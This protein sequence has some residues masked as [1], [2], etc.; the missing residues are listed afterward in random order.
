MVGMMK[1]SPDVIVVG[2]SWTQDG[3]ALQGVR[4]APSLHITAQRA[5]GLQDR[6]AAG[7]EILSPS[8]DDNVGL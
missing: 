2:A 8:G 7:V 4:Q 6:I 1:R 5:S 3:V